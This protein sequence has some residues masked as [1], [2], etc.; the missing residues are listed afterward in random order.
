[1]TLHFFV[2]G[3]PVP[4]GSM[5]AFVSHTTKRIVMPQQYRRSHGL[6]TICDPPNDLNVPSEIPNQMPSM[7]LWRAVVALALTDLESKNERARGTARAFFASPEG[8][9]IIEVIRPCS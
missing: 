8:K 2:P 9:N 6:S 4:Q 3:K 7:K 5:S 1:M